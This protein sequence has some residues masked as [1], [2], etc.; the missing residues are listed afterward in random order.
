MINYQI[1]LLIKKKLNWDDK[2]TY[3]DLLELQ[4]KAKE[5][6]DMIKNSEDTNNFV[7]GIPN[8]YQYLDSL[9]LLQEVSLLHIS[10]FL[11]LILTVINILSVLF[12]NEIVRYFNLEKRLPKLSGFFRLR[13]TLQR[14]YLMW[15]VLIL[16][17]F[18]L[19]GIGVNLLLFTVT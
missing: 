5:L 19:F 9:T 15:N 3:S 7:S 17:V 13:A 10:M 18:C 1:N 11:V 16:F 8:F 6:Y 14:Y 4:Q 2:G 12:G